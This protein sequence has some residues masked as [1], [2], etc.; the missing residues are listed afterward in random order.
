MISICTDNSLWKYEIFEPFGELVTNF[1]TSRHGGF[2]KGNYATFNPSPYSGDDVSV[3]ERNLNK[4]KDSLPQQPLYLFR[5]RQ[6]HGVELRCIDQAFLALSEDEQKAKLTGID[7]ICT[8]IPG[9][10][11]CV[12]TADCVPI[13]LYDTKRKAVAAV[14]AGW[15]GT[16]QRILVHTI[17][18]MKELYGTEAQDL[19]AAIGPSISLASFE[20]G[21]EVYQA[22]EDASFDMKA[23]SIWKEST[24]KHHIDLWK[25]NAM[26]LQE[27][28]VPDHHIQIAGIC[29]Y[30]HQEDFFSARRLGI[31]SGRIL[32]GIML[33]Q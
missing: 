15:R 10:A 24:K 16:V 7:A 27:N 14:H 6:V 18:Q 31:K 29:T 25:A 3:V 21:E 20:I 30:I 28:G 22:F 11:V 4:L 5:P 8:N 23:I 32:S 33:N 12:S 26:Q 1:V 13:L 17:K 2:S 9:Y 19:Y